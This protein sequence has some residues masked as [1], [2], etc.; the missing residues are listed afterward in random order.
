MRPRR[1]ARPLLECVRDEND[2]DGGEVERLLDLSCA[3]VD[4]M[5]ELENVVRRLRDVQAARVALAGIPAEDVRR[6][7]TQ[8]RHRLGAGG[9]AG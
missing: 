6:A 8:R 9:R 2:R 1:G 7:I 3:W 4:A 5:V